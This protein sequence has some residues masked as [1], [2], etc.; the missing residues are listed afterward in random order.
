RLI[1]PAV[2]GDDVCLRE[3]PTDDIPP[4]AG[5]VAT[6]PRPAAQTIIASDNGDPILA[7]W[8]C[9]L[10]HTIAFTSEPKPVCADDWVHWCEFAKFLSQLVRTVIGEN[11]SVTVSVEC[12]HQVDGDDLRLTADISDAAGNF[13]SDAEVELTSV[14]E[15]VRTSALAVERR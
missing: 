3:I 15:A 9:G 6:T 10:G 13:Q 14:D 12:S 8:R 2:V 4:L 7:K 11:L 5:Y 1:Q